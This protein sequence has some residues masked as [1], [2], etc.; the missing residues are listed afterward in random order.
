MGMDIANYISM[1]LGYLDGHAFT[2][3]HDMLLKNM[4]SFSIDEEN[5]SDYLTAL[6]RDKKNTG[7]G[8]TCIFASGYGSVRK[9]K[10]QLDEKLRDVIVEYFRKVALVI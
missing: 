10:I 2:D 6:S 8:L 7:R 9:V 3:M 5:I 1:Q 4:P